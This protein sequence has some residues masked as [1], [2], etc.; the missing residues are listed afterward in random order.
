MEFLYTL[1]PQ[2]KTEKELVKKSFLPFA[3]ELGLSKNASVKEYIDTA[4]EKFLQ[5]DYSTVEILSKKLNKTLVR[6]DISTFKRDFENYLHYNP[7]YALASLVCYQNAMEDGLIQRNSKKVI[8][9]YI[10]N[11]GNHEIF[12]LYNLR[13]VEN[14]INEQNYISFRSGI[15]FANNFRENF[16]ISPLEI[17][18]ISQYNL[19]H[20]E[21]EIGRLSNQLLSYKNQSKVPNFIK[22]KISELKSI[23]S[24]NKKSFNLY[25]DKCD[26][27]ML[28]NITIFKDKYLETFNNIKY[29]TN[30]KTAC[31]HMV[32]LDK[33][34]KSGYYPQHNNRIYDKVDAKIN[35]NT[36]PNSTPLK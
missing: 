17:L 5:G 36:P 22:R 20:S 35:S 24:N 6:K 32:F 25:F 9:D 12:H 18:F 14:S 15:D 1:Y 21:K 30:S 28:K 10:K 4:F 31:F 34:S 7:I 13:K 2:T 3:E 33:Y 16:S 26:V 11:G 29:V 8:L 23:M 27:H 19:V